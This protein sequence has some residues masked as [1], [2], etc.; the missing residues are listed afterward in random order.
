[1]KL[2]I[3]IFHKHNKDLN[4]LLFDKQIERFRIHI[5]NKK[6]YSFEFDRRRDKIRIFFENLNTFKST[7]VDLKIIASFDN[8]ILTDE[9]V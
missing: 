2:L 1:M 6:N 5:M 9:I 8:S 3:D 4:F 7:I